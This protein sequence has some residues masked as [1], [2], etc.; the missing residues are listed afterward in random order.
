MHCT[1]CYLHCTFCSV[2]CTLYTVQGFNSPR[3]FI[4]TQ[5]PLA[6]TRDDYWRMCW[7]S[8]SR[9]IIMLTRCIEKGREKCDHYW[10][11][12]TQPAYYGDIQVTILN[13]MDSLIEHDIHSQGDQSRIIRHFH[14]TTWPDFGVPDPPQALV[15]FVRAFR[16]RVPP[17]HRPIVVHCRQLSKNLNQN[18]VS[19]CSAGVGR[20]GTFIAL[21]RILQSIRVSDY[22]DIFGIVYEMRRERTCMVQNE[23]QYI[24]IHQCLMVVIQGLE[25]L[26]L[27]NRPIETHTN[28]AYE[29]DEGIA[30]SGM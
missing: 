4:V 15:R 20:S 2:H 30:E 28:R 23:Q 17:D 21:D 9:A 29:D 16:E 25:A 8:N 12:D 11:Y 10:P 26:G 24:C 1:L 13:E 14:F 22:V 27:S 7:E 19:V 6:S 18:G 5:G 3:E